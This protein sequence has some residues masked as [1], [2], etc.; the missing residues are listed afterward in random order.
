MD[1]THRLGKCEDQHEQFSETILTT[2]HHELAATGYQALRTVNCEY[3]QGAVVLRG[4]VS[5]YYLKQLRKQLYWHA[6]SSRQWLIRSK[7][8]TCPE[9]HID[10]HHQYNHSRDSTSPSSW[11][12]IAPS[13]PRDERVSAGSRT[14]KATKLA[15]EFS[16]NVSVS[17]SIGQSVRICRG[18]LAGSSG[19]VAELPAPGRA[20]IRLQQDVHFEID[21]SCLKPGNVE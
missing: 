19:T 11:V 10:S 15:S 17:F 9:V 20:A 3:C 4:R 13:M 2:A 8:W 12:R 6:R 1:V 14:M 21:Q 18:I 7:L 5:S 16:S